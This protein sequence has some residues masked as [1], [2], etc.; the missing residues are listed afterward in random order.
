[1]TS[2]KDLS[3]KELY[4]AFRDGDSDECSFEVIRERIQPGKTFSEEALANMTQAIVLFIGGRIM[5]RWEK[6]K[7]PPSILKVD[8]KVAVQ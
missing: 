4:D 5:A 3:R 8:V 6:T 7:E 1:M 2:K